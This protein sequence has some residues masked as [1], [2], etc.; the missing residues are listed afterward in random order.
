MGGRDVNRSGLEPSNFFPAR[1]CVALVLKVGKA[2]WHF[3]VLAFA[4]GT[5]GTHLK[6]SRLGLELG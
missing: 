4:L 3:H 6:T 5:G 2:I 1:K